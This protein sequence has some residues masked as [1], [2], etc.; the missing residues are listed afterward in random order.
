MNLGLQ[1]LRAV[2]GEVAYEPGARLGPRVQRDLQLVLMHQGEAWIQVDEAARHLR[3]GEAGLLRP[4]HREYFEFSRHGRT[5][6]SWCAVAYP[7]LGD[8]ASKTLGA[9]PF[10][11]P[12]SDRLHNLVRLGL[13][14]RAETRPSAEAL[15]RRLGEAALWEFFYLLSH[16]GEPGL[17]ESVERVR[18][19]V[20]AR[21]PE[22]LD[23]E[24]LA[25]VACVSAPHL[26]RLFRKHLQTTPIR[27][28]WQVRLQE[29]L[30]M[31]RETGL[32]ISEIAFRCGYQNPFHF[33]RA[34]KG[35][36]GLPPRLYR[37]KSWRR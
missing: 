25:A 5:H 10:L 11:A 12:L 28:L 15:K 21:Y 32:T 36:E 19:H 34:V 29:G 16:D 33:S 35:V 3:A 18:A 23:L 17:P 24:A 30:R 14:L 20:H 9:L 37:E 13:G 2:F 8:A 27:Y 22:P 26:T 1:P 31:L 4:G 6:H 7:S